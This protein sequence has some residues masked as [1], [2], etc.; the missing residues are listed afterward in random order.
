[1]R[2]Y[3]WN[4]IDWAKQIRTPEIDWAKQMK[5]PE[6]GCWTKPYCWK[7]DESES[8]TNN[9]NIQQQLKELSDLLDESV[10]KLNKIIEEKE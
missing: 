8:H 1:M 2:I 6:I 3:G 10:D 9:N 7:E 5:P 4:K